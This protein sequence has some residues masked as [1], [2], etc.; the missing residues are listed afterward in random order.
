M[1]CLLGMQMQC[2]ALSSGWLSNGY[3]TEVRVGLVTVVIVRLSF[4]RLI[5]GERKGND[6]PPLHIGASLEQHAHSLGKDQ[7]D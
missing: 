4:I 2:A 1:V 5:S 3:W 7:K 6:F